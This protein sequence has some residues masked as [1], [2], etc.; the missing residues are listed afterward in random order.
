MS[1]KA[2]SQSCVIKR[3][4][5]HRWPAI[6]GAPGEG[7]VE[8]FDHRLSTTLESVPSQ[9]DNCSMECL[10]DVQ[11]PQPVALKYEEARQRVPQ[12]RER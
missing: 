1:T 5:V 8:C 3:P 10:I 4:F 11:T 12:L 6:C 2:L 9:W 7:R